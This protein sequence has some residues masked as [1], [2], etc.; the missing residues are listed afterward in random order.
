MPG[1]AIEP[2]APSELP[3][4]SFHNPHCLVGQAIEPKATGRGPRT[5]DHHLSYRPR[6]I[7]R[8]LLRS[9]LWNK[10]VANLVTAAVIVT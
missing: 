8:L 3:L 6:R 1:Q 5:E 4:T 2:K 7:L 9:A 10:T